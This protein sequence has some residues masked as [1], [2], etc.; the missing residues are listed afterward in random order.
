MPAIDNVVCYGFEK[1]YDADGKVWVR[2]KYV[3]DGVLNTPMVVVADETGYAFYDLSDTTANCYIGVPAKAY[4]TGVTGPIQI[5]GRVTAMIT[6]SLSVSAGHGLL[7]HDGAV[8]D[9]NADY[10]GNTS[11]FAVC[12][13]AS[14]SST[15]QDVML[16]PERILSTT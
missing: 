10:Y 2:G 11:E 14:S 12:I 3:H 1:S 5:G 16:V 9:A 8:A 13:T 15:T 4:A 7:F 6:P